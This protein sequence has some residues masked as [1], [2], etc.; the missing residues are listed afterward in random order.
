LA[1]DWADRVLAKYSGLYSVPAL[2][3]T[4]PQ[5]AAYTLG[6]NAHFDE[7]AA[8]V[9]AVYDA[10]T[11]TV[12]VTSPA[13]GTVTVSGAQTADSTTYGTEVS[14]SISLTADVPVTFTSRRLP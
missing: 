3:P 9:D 11:E 1:S 10:A 2:A 4:W 5:L 13:S 14:A 12:T 7:L 6:R 8:G